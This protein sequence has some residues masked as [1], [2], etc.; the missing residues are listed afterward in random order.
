MNKIKNIFMDSLKIEKSVLSVGEIEVSPYLRKIFFLI[1]T[2]V[3]L[4]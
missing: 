2:K 3:G 1:I 4:D